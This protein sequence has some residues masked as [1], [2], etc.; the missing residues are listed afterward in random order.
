MWWTHRTTRPRQ[1]TGGAP[2]SGVSSSIGVRY[3]LR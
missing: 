3:E 2:L 1:I